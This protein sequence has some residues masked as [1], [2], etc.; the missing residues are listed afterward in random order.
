MV[1]KY[2]KINNFIVLAICVVLNFFQKAVHLL[3]MIKHQ[4]KI[5]K[6]CCLDVILNF[7]NRKTKVWSTVIS[8]LCS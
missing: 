3:L 2:K 6:I 1:R 4:N 5:I 7:R 8:I